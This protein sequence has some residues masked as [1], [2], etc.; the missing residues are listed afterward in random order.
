[1][2]VEAT[3]IP[4]A[5][6]LPKR[7]IPAPVIAV[8]GSDGSGKS[9]VT[10]T[11]VER[12]SDGMES[13]FIYFGTGDGPGSMLRKPLVWLKNNSKYRENK[14]PTTKTARKK[15]NVP[16]FA[17][18]LWAVS[19]AFERRGKMKQARRFAAEGMLVIT[20]RY[21]QVEYPGIHD[22]PRLAEWIETDRRGPARWLA[23][24]ESGVYRKLAAQTPDLVLLLDV[25][26]D[27]ALSRRPEEP[28]DE[29]ERRIEIARALRFGKAERTVIDAS[30][31]LESVLAKATSEV[32]R[33]LH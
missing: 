26:L 15:Q 22:G 25:S 6:R 19:V 3:T 24:W 7:R 21:P 17:K 14:T 32:L 30:E 8:I 1:M 13:R 5:E 16:G 12:F 27:V 23:D 11:L 4:L 29:L 28:R 10:S 18:A 2:T 31:P 33:K 20:D 9:T